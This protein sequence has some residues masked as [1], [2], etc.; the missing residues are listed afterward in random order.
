MVFITSL[1]D[2]PHRTRCE[3]RVPLDLPISCGKQVLSKL[4]AWHFLQDASSSTAQS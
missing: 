2:H 3:R 4:S 1:A